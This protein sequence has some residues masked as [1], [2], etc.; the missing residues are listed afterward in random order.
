MTFWRNVVVMDDGCWIIR[1]ESGD[2]VHKT[3]T[4]RGRTDYAHRV[5][6]QLHFGSIPEGLYVCHACDV[7]A[8]VNPDHLWLGTAGDNNR[9][10][11]SKGRMGRMREF[12]VK[13]KTIHEI[14]AA[15]PVRVRG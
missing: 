11:S 1:P 8:C 14:H 5:A 4:I 7:C 2:S 6:W 10:A 15:T 3:F 9:D 12:T 13:R